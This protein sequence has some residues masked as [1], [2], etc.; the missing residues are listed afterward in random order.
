M[1]TA[2]ELHSHT[3]TMRPGAAD[4]LLAMRDKATEPLVQRNHAGSEQEAD[5]LLREAV[6]TYASLVAGLVDLLSATWEEG[7]ELFPEPYNEHS[8]GF[9]RTSGY[10]GGLLWH[11]DTGRYQIHT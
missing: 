9:C 3:I 5:H 8:L 7:T 2:P 4:R 10:H 1:T 6:L 11:Q